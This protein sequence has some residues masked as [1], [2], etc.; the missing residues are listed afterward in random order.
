[1]KKH[2]IA[3]IV[4]KS[5]VIHDN[6]ML[7][8]HI[9]THRLPHPQNLTVV[10]IGN[11]VQSFWGVFHVRPGWY[12]SYFQFSVYICSLTGSSS[13]PLQIY[14]LLFGRFSSSEDNLLFTTRP[15]PTP[16][17]N[18]SHHRVQKFAVT[19][20]TDGKPINRCG[21]PIHPVFPS[22]C[23]CFTTGKDAEKLITC[24][25]MVWKNASVS[26]ID[27]LPSIFCRSLLGTAGPLQRRK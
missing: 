22:T 24:V 6:S 5:L 18:L 16:W 13:K 3:K 11:Q 19:N 23:S 15:V 14:T 7:T 20:I 9:A 1:M 26:P 2:I 27:F 10:G 12:K 25:I 21:K 4:R 17:A 8:E